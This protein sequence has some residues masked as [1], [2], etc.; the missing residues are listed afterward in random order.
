VAGEVGLVLLSREEAQLG[1]TGETGVDED[2]DAVEPAQLEKAKG[3][4]I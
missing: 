3:F 4:E 1:A 2:V